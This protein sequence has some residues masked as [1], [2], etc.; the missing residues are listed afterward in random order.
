MK[1]LY[2]IYESI[3][4][5]DF[6]DQVED[7]MYEEQILDW[8]KQHYT[9][10]EDGYYKVRKEKGQFYVDAETAILSDLRATSL[11]NGMF[12][13]GEVY[14]FD[15]SSSLVED[16][17]GCPDTTSAF[18]CASCQ[19]IKSL[20]GIPTKC[21]TLAIQGI[22]GL[23]SFE[24]IPAGVKE[25]YASGCPN[26]KT[27]KGCPKSLKKLWIDGCSSLKNLEGIGKV[28]LELNCSFCENLT[29]LKGLPQLK[30]LGLLKLRSCPKLESLEGSPTEVKTLDIMRTP[31]LD[32]LDG[33]PRYVKT[34]YYTRGRYY[35][36]YINSHCEVDKIVAV[37]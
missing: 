17:E 34:L 30:K 1:N 22:P 36:S 26:L 10:P 28:S 33:M 11:T 20:K 5:D 8:I 18:K 27:L 21:E 13:W 14:V 24:G 16:F 37:D 32:Y 7:A 9:W 25:I 12:K 6:E 4:D 23:T 35:E 3:F 2:D 19:R 15:C 29:S 31:K